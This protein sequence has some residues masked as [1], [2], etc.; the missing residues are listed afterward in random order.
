M[1]LISK[2]KNHHNDVNIMRLNAERTYNKLSKA[3]DDTMSYVI[4]QH[5]TIQGF[6]PYTYL[7]PRYTRYLMHLEKLNKKM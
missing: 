6:K 4:K 3:I 5:N 1:S 7:F 2:I